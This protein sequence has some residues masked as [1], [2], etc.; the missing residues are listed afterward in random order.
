LGS[1][2]VFSDDGIA[3][4]AIKSQ[5]TV[6]QHASPSNLLKVA[7]GDG[8]W[9]GGAGSPALFVQ[10][11][12]GGVAVQQVETQ[13]LKVG[14][15]VQ[16]T[17]RVRPKI[18]SPTMEQ[19]TVR[20]LWE[21]TPMPPVSVTASQAATGAFDATFIEVEGRLAGKERGPDDA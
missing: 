9:N 8:P 11:A 17:G 7:H 12:T 1:V 5:C 6:D 2:C 20:V 14:D 10:D 15:E 16:V 13:A 4:A 19:A 18:F 21:N 3:G